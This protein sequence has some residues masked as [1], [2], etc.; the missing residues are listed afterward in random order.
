MLN[1]MQGFWME[2]WRLHDQIKD[3][4]RLF[5]VKNESDKNQSNELKQS[6]ENNGENP[7]QRKRT[8]KQNIGLLLGPIL[9]ALTLLFVSPEGMSREAQAVLAS[10]LWV[11]VWWITEA[12]PIPVTSLLPIILFPVTGAVTEGITSSYADN[13]IFLFLGGFIIAIAME[14]WN[15][16]LRI[17]LGII[18]VV[19]TST[20]RLVLGF[21][22][23]TGF[24]SMWISNTATAMMMMPIAIAVITHVNDSMKSER[25]SANRFGK[26][27]MLGIAYAASIGG[28]GTL[29]GTPPNMIFAGVV[30][31][32]YGIDISFATWM[33][34]GVP[35]AAILLLVAWFYLIKMAFPMR[36]KELPGGKEII[37]SERKRLGNISFEEKLVLVVFLATAVAWITR[38]FIPFDFMSRIDDTIIAIAAAIILFLL[39]SKSSKDSQLLNWKDALNI[40]WGILLLFGGGLAIAK[41]FKDSGLATWIG[42]QLTVLEGVHLVIVIL[43]VT[44]LVTFLTEI[45]SNTATATMMFP[46][47]ASLALALDLHP[48][49]LMVAAAIAASCAF[50]L[51]VATPPNAIV[52][53]SGYLKIGDMAK[54]GFWLSIFTIIFVGVMI[55]FYMPIAWGIDIGTFPN[56]FK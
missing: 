17:A 38:S 43:C 8:K 25:E 36:I 27:L 32:I 51:P 50:M 21:M 56:S 30:K 24:L 13:T 11:A 3:L 7:K 22:V 1:Y 16:H 9:F 29:I 54:S 52:F 23:A 44:A 6:D 34:F 28:L 53:G 5:S 39:P 26:S 45:T 19:G 15:L 49:A 47:M 55:Y 14:K 46:I 40:P 18:T 2:M 20:S 41:G 48:Y 10:T 31:E 12:I 37:S 4:L 42:E 35:F 33:L